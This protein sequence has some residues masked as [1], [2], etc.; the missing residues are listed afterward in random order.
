MFLRLVS[1]CHEAHTL[2]AAQDGR[3]E[4]V[5]TSWGGGVAACPER[6]EWI[7]SRGKISKALIF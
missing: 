2:F 7:G 1:L 6:I 5:S 4:L 3:E